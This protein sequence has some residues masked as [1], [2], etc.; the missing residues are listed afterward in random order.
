MQITLKEPV[1]NDFEISKHYVHFP[2]SR[3]YHHFQ[4]AYEIY[5]ALSGNRYYFIN[6]K[7]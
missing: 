4:N 5:Y 7:T 6:D 2:E 3:A 1:K